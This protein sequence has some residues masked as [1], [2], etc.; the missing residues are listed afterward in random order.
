MAHKKEGTLRR[1]N[2]GE[3][4]LNSAIFMSIT[5]YNKI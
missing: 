2:L 3:I 5:P 1:L 4:S